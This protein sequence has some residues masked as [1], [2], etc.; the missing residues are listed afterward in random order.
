[1]EN[2][3]ANTILKRVTGKE[4]ASVLTMVSPFRIDPYVNDSFS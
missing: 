1:M 3:F 4:D 2:W